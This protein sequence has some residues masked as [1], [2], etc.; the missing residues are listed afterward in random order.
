MPLAAAPAC[1]VVGAR[2]PDGRAWIA[3]TDDIAFEE[4]G[5]NIARHDVTAAGAASLHLHFAG[6]IW[7]SL[8]LTADGFCM[9]MTGME[10]GPC[11][12]DGLPGQ[13]LWRIVPD[14]CRT[15]REAADFIRGFP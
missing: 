3:K 4:L 10:S 1:S 14:R 9:A 13:V 15:A 6:T 2:D 11:P 5:S 7:T 12:A 8:A